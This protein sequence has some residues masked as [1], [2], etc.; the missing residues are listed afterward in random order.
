MKL[1][2]HV[3]IGKTGTSSIQETLRENKSALECQKTFYIGLNT[4]LSPVQKFEWQSSG[5][6][7]KVL[8]LEPKEAVRQLSLLLQKTL[9]ELEKRKIEKVIWSNESLINLPEIVIPTL[10]SLKKNGYEIDI[11]AYIRRHDAWARS[12]YLQWGIKHKTY[13]GAVIPFREWV[14][15]G[16]SFSHLVKPWIAEKWDNTYIRNFDTCVELL[17]DFF[18]CCNLSVANISIAR[19]YDTP[20]NVALNMWALFNSQR[21]NA[22]LPYELE[23]LFSKTKIRDKQ[24]KPVGLDNIFPKEEDLKQVL[25]EAQNDMDEIDRIFARFKQPKLDRTPLKP[26]DFKVSGEE[27][28]CGL[29]DIVQSQH[30]MIGNLERKLSRIEAS[31]AERE[32]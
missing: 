31:I 7:H 24:Y 27:L 11:I 12:A 25:T 19:A 23:N 5:S 16:V 21:H 9:I 22:V 1:I 29:L 6:W 8:E 20:G 18:N 15:K 28:F 26:K 30:V 3:G 17:T 32:K 10:K 14:K 2:V 13:Q 4:E